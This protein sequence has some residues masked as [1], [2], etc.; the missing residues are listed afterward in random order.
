MNKCPFCLKDSENLTKEHVFPK[1]WYPDDLSSDIEKWT[2]PSCR[3]CNSSFGKLEQEILIFAALC[4]DPNNPTTK[5]IS[6]RALRSIN[7]NAGR[8]ERDRNARL[9]KAESI[10]TKAFP[11]S[12]SNKKPF[13][14]FGYHEGYPEESQVGIDVPKGLWEIG[15]KFIKGIEYKLEDRILDEN[16]RVE[17]RFCDEETVKD[18]ITEIRRGEKYDVAS[19]IKF[20]RRCDIASSPKAILYEIRIWDKLTIYGYAIENNIT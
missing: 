17:A 3:E 20:Y 18:V 1:S 15:K 14:G 10:F 9:K 5:T 6:D 16:F 7:A 2:V 8:N 12:D 11:V 19:T 13:P 4:F